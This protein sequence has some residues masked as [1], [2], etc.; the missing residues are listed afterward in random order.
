MSLCSV[1][2]ERQ[3]V[4]IKDEQDGEVKK[5]ESGIVGENQMLSTSFNQVCSVLLDL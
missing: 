5:R 2:E 3:E 1:A 4:M